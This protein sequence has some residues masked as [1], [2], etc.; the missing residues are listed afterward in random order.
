MLI[1][2]IY[3]IIALF[4]IYSISIKFSKYNFYKSFPNPYFLYPDSL[5][6]SK[7]T[8]EATFHRTKL[9][10]D[11]FY[12]INLDIYNEFLY[13]L[14]K[15]NIKDITINELK[16]IDNNL[17][18]LKLYQLF[19]NRLPPY[20]VNTKIK[21]L[22]NNF[23]TPCYPSELSFKNHLLYNKYATKYP[24]A[25]ETLFNLTNKID[26]IL[27]SSGLHYPSDI[28]KSKQLSKYF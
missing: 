14:K 5:E 7:I 3:F 20:L 13:I 17:F 26:N 28:E 9:D 23:N 1:M 27:I 10:R 4:I 22:S 18:I 12:K 19:Y 8:Y 11:F 24:F 2:I 16:S 25:S 6:E 21:E 15:H